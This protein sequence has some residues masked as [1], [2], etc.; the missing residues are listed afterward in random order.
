MT[1]ASG[2]GGGFGFGGGGGG[3]D[4]DDGGGGGGGGGGGRGGP[5][6]LHLPRLELDECE[7]GHLLAAP[8]KP[9]IP[10]RKYSRVRVRGREASHAAATSTRDGACFEACKRRVRDFP[11]GAEHLLHLLKRHLAFS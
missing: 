10:A 1:S 6:Y 4:D 3:G 9:C 8:G 7:A 11:D 5:L 2:F